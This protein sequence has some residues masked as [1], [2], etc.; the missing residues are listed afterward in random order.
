M[1]HDDAKLLREVQKNTEMGMTAIDTILD[2]IGDDEFSLQLSKQ[3]LRYS[4]IHNRALEQSLQNEGEVYR[5]SQIADMALR[6]SIHMN[7]VFNISRGH[8]AGMVIPES[9]RDITD[10]WKA[11]KHNSLATCQAMEIA[12]ELVDFEQESIERMKEYL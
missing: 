4:E 8:L 10:M 12:Q 5:G 1:K 7:T 11:M 3:A 9:N 2:K 6:G